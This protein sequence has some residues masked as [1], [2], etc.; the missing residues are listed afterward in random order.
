MRRRYRIP[1]E[2]R[3]SQRRYS[4]STLRSCSRV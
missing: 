2:W 1:A 4:G 3:E